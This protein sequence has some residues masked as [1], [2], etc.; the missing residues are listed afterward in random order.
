MF[1]LDKKYWEVRKTNKKGLGVFAKKEILKGTVIG[2]YTGKLVELKD[3]DF[4]EEKKNMYLMYYDDNRGIYP[5]LTKPGVH[6]INHSCSPNAWLINHKGHTLVF[7]LND[8][9]ENDETTIS[10]LL[11]PKTNC[12][13]CP[14]RCFCKSNGCT[15]TMHL[16]EKKYQTWQSFLS[17]KKKVYIK[18]VYRKVLPPLKRYP[19]FVSKKYITSVNKL[20]I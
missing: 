8:I 4:E 19:R 3:L 11:P 5:D 17:S 2:D 6:L 18:P 9:L 12:V 1:L 7:A 16:T 13:N 14:H 10:Y 20:K 15:G